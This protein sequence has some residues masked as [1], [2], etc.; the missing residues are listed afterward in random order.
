M[1]QLI[2]IKNIKQSS[3]LQ[4]RAK[5]DTAVIDEYT[6]AMKRGDAFPAV[7][8]VEIDDHYYLVDGYH[9]FMAAQGAK[10]GKILA[11]VMIGGTMRDAILYSAGVNAKHGLNRTN[12]DKRRAVMILLRDEKWSKW[13]DTQIATACHVSVD[14]VAKIRDSSLGETERNKPKIRKILR[15]GKVIEMDTSKIGKRPLTQPSADHPNH[16]Q[17][18]AQPETLPVT[19]DPMQ[20]SLAEQ[21]AG[22]EPAPATE[23]VPETSEEQ[24]QEP[25]ILI[26][27][28]VKETADEVP[29]TPAD[30]IAET[31]KKIPACHRGEPCPGM[32]LEKIRGKVCKVLGVPINQLPLNECPHDHKPPVANSGF[33]HAG[34]GAPSIA[35]LARMDALKT[36][37]SRNPQELTIAFGDDEWDVLKRVVSEGLAESLEDAVRYVVKDAGERMV[38]A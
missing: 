13:A 22:K 6:A 12:D 15:K 24:P 19:D 38:G 5:M 4:P 3:E 29:A 25:P 23:E 14:L 37:N 2:P 18:V 21:Q 26:N 7:T 31:S 33:V 11:D 8:V 10:I 16:G 35:T 20:P 9:R 28:L 30:K 32:H 1:T 17:H 34:T 27:H 36:L